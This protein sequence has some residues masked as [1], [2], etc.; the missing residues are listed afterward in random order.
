VWEYVEPAGKCWKG[1]A[2]LFQTP[3]LTTIGNTDCILATVNGRLVAIGLRDGKRLAAAEDAH[4][5]DVYLTPQRVNG[6]V[7]VTPAINDPARLFSLR[8]GKLAPIW[9]SSDIRASY[10]T[11]LCHGDYLFGFHN[12]TDKAKFGTGPYALRCVRVADGKMVWEQAEGF[13]KPGVS[14]LLADGLLFI[15]NETA[16]ILAEASSAGYAENGRL[17][18]GSDANYGWVM[19]TLSNGRLYVRGSNQLRCYQVAET[20]P[21]AAV[22]NGAETTSCA[23]QDDRW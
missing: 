8:D 2:S 14:L 1:G 17:K 3:Q 12:A 6:H 11:W 15:R 18:I 21:D 16:L 23:A 19:P 13:E 20:L 4:F 5:A 22:I 9:Q 10:A 7:L